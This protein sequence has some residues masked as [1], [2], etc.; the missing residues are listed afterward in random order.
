[1]SILR[2]TPLEE[3]TIVEMKDLEGAGGLYSGVIVG[4]SMRSVVDFYIVR[5]DKPVPGYPYSCVTIPESM[6]T[7]IR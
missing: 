2:E 6:I 1:M 7:S 5:L 4:L 3:G